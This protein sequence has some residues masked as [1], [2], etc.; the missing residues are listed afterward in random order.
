M[1]KNQ[2]YGSGNETA[3]RSAST[4]DGLASTS[5]EEKGRGQEPALGRDTSTYRCDASRSP[6]D[7][8]PRGRSFHSEL[9]RLAI[10]AVARLR[11]RLACSP[12]PAERRFVLACR[13]CDID[14]ALRHE[15]ADREHH[16]T[17]LLSELAAI[18]EALAGWRGD[19]TKRRRPSRIG[20]GSARGRAQ[21]PGSHLVPLQI[22]APEE[23]A[24]EELLA[25]DVATSFLRA[26]EAGGM[27]VIQTSI[28]GGLVRLLVSVR[29]PII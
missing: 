11:C 24:D 27:G 2:N 4:A 25:L 12:L 1:Q 13:L 15:T 28:V 3:N 10:H 17:S 14:A 22:L 8:E 5:S 26:A 18:T 29:L 16:L 9:A 21:A 23:D 19:R 20:G 6:A 7:G